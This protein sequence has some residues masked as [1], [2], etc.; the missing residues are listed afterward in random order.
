VDRWDRVEHLR[1]YAAVVHV[2]AGEERGEGDAL[3]VD[4]QVALRA[5]LAAIRR[6]RPG[7]LAPLFAG[8]LVESTEAR[9]QSIRSASPS[10]FSSA[11]SRRAHT[12][13]AC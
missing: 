6:I 11:R 4:H 1:E 7:R 5:L 8:T 13:A 9:L 12:P 10:R 2:R 3:G